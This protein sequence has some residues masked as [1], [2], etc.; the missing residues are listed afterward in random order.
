MLLRADE[1]AKN[2]EGG[3][4]ISDEEAQVRATYENWA[5]E[6]DGAMDTLGW[7]GILALDAFFLV[8]CAYRALYT[9]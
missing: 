2:P 5:A 7:R 6:Y 3:K 8:T 9:H 1:S 4:K